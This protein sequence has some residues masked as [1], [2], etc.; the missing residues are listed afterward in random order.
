MPNQILIGVTPPL[1]PEQ[2]SNASNVL[3]HD[4]VQ[5]VNQYHTLAVKVLNK[6]ATVL[7]ARWQVGEQVWLEGKNLLLPYGSAKLMP[8]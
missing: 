3:A 6:K 7:E 4:Q 2:Q 8:H 1:S 5:L